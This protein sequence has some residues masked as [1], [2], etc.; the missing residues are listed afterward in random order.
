[1]EYLKL[2]ATAWRNGHA[3][4]GGIILTLYPIQICLGLNIFL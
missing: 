4:L 3:A 2:L 1:M